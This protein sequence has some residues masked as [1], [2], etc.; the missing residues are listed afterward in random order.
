MIRKKLLGLT[1]ATLFATSINAETVMSHGEWSITL[2]DDNAM[3]IAYGGRVILNKAYASVTYNVLGSSE[4]KTISSEDGTMAPVVTSGAT[5]DCFGQGT[6][7]TLEY[8]QDGG[9]MTQT[10]CFYDALP[11]MI[12][13]VSIAAEDGATVQSR[14]LTALGSNT[15]SRPLDG[16]SNRMLYVPFD[17]DGNQ[18]ARFVTAKLSDE[19]FSHEVTAVFNPDTRRGL[20]FGSVDHDTWKSLAYVRGDGGYDMTA[21]ECRS[22]YTDIL[23]RDVLPHGK[24]KGQTVS[25]AR[26]LFGVFDD[27]RDGMEAFAD[28]CL[29]V[30][31]RPEW[32]GGNP[33]GW[34]TWGTAMEYVTFNGVID[35]SRFIKDELYDKGFHDRNGQT[36]ISIDAFGSDNIT[37]ARFSAMGNKYFG[38]GDF[39]DGSVTGAGTNQI[40]GQYGG[41]F[42]AWDW[43]LGSTV[44]GSQYTYK[45]IALRINGEVKG[46]ASN[47]GH[48]CP[49]DPTHPGVEANIKRILEKWSKWNVK[50]IKVDF[51]NCGILEGDSWYN[52]DIT[53]GVQAYNY[54]MRILREEAEKYGMYIV[55][56][57]SPLFPYN[58]AHGRR[59]YCDTFSGIGESES[60]MTTIT[61]GWWTSRLYTVNDP[62]QLVFYKRDNGNETEGENRARAT[63]GMVTGAYIFGDNFSESIVYNKEDNGHAAGDVVGWP[64]KARAMALKIMG[65]E[66]VNEYVRENTGSFRPVEVSASSSYLSANGAAKIYVKDTDKYWYVAVFNFSSGILGM[67]F[68]G[69]ISFDRLGIDASNVG[70]AK[71][72]WLNEGVTMSATGLSYSVPKADARIYRIS[73]LASDSETGVRETGAEQAGEVVDTKAYDLLGHPVN[74]ATASGIVVMRQQLRDGGYITRKVMR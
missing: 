57:I 26:F 64:E 36:V 63:S 9:I 16:A 50:Y 33:M 7:Y 3:T 17:N 40:L 55:E 56:S 70:E 54:G 48:G 31:P 62:D 41:F 44:E 15:Q 51:L 25:S 34:S 5:E 46:L 42:V 60:V 22:G 8:R 66:D 72:L 10:L 37:N 28:A 6:A 52:P 14:R 59:V 58:Y 18:Q 67:T 4:E 30:A 23:T 53:T 20:V 38:V 2:A 65:N 21:M 1:L 39:K 27:W 11:Y 24:V 61:G 68:N 32:D 29:A 47:G 13:Q 74:P 43:S 69:S 12:A 45:D 73:K 71:E 49:V 35:A 19:N